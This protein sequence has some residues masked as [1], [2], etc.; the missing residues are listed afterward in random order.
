MGLSKAQVE[1]LRLDLAQAEKQVADNPRFSAA[2]RYW[3]GRLDAI[4]S[5]NNIIDF[6]KE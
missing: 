2:A 1:S 3:A 4:K 6:D 5:V